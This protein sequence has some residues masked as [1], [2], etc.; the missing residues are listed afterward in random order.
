[1]AIGQKD[2]MEPH[3]S[4]WGYFLATF[5]ITIVPVLKHLKRMILRG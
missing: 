3:P 5:P 1:M 2:L 4:F